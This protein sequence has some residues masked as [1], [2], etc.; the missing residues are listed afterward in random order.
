MIYVVNE[1]A[2]VAAV[3]TIEVEAQRAAVGPIVL[4]TIAHLQRNKKLVNVIYVK[5]VNSYIP[6]AIDCKFYNCLY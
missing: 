4:P 2:Q 3:W 5:E 1:I 6:K